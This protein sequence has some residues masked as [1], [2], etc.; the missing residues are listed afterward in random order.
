LILKLRSIECFDDQE[1][2]EEFEGTFLTSFIT[3]NSP[4]K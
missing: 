3:H 1:D 4:D 2:E